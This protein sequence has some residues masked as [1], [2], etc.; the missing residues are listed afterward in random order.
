MR[1]GDSNPGKTVLV[2]T[3]AHRG[4]DARIA[5]RQ[6]AA[7]T[8][9]GMNVVYAAPEPA[10][11]LGPFVQR[12]VLP[13]ARGR[14]RLGCWVAAMRTIRAHRGSVDLVL[15]HD[16][17]IV[18]PVR[19]ARPRVPVV[20][21]VHEDVVASIVDRDWIPRRARALA[22]WMV[23][24]I[25]WVA[26]RD[27][28][29]ILA[30]TSYRD[31]LGDWPV[32]P[33]STV[34]PET[35]TEQREPRRVVYVG[36]ISEG[37]GVHGMIELAERLG[38]R[39]EVILAGPADADIR[40]RLESAHEA[41]ILQWRGPLPNP[42]ALRLIASASVGLCLLEPLPN[43]WGS[44]PTKVYEYLAYGTPVVATSLPLA[45][46]AIAA[47]GGGVIAPFDDADFVA[48]AVEGYL[49]DPSRARRD[50]ERGHRWVLAHH[51]WAIDGPAFASQVSAWA[52]ATNP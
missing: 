29:L 44:M 38:D 45:V 24:S 25:E 26:T 36:R 8:A 52:A 37:R 16:L 48:N 46:D 14:R 39:A 20:W 33:N 6:I 40:V 13:R 9:A 4:D 28:K 43:Y 11:D 2:V 3:V 7:L 27:I 49:D 23:R 21:D 10:P 47:S 18:L 1:P 17:E 30:E 22:R 32:V 35:L 19:L 41:G 12:L 31:R 34:V 51:N 42:E 15:V 50:G 5:Y